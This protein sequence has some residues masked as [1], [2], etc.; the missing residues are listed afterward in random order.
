MSEKLSDPEFFGTLRREVEAAIDRYVYH[1]PA[2][3]IGNPMS[4]AAITSGLARMRAALI[5]PYWLEVE[6][7]DTFDQVRMNTGPRRRC[8]V[9]ADDGNGMLLLFDPFEEDYAL[10][11]RTS[12]GL[13]TFG[14]RGDA[15]G[16]FLAR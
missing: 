2:G 7:R 8:A 9:V 4:D 10:A 6:L 15:V 12:S 11:H 1:I 14:V 13:K 5:P 3:T 16:C